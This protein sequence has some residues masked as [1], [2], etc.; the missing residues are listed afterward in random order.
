M[1]LTKMSR[2]KLLV[3]SAWASRIITSIA[4]I[5]SIRILNA[6]LQVEEY[7]IYIVIISISGWFTIIGDPGIGY[8][9]QNKISEKIAIKKNYCVDILGAYILLFSIAIFI[10][11]F[12]YILKNKI[13]FFLFGNINYNNHDELIKVFVIIA[14]IYSMSVAAS[15]SNKF[16]YAMGSG[17]FSNAMTAM[18]SLLGLAALSLGI[19]NWSQKIMYSI[20]A[21]STPI[22]M[23]SFIL[24]IFQIKKSWSSI[25]LVKLNILL[26]ILKE[27]RGFFFFS[28]IATFIIQVDYLIMTQQV[29]PVEIAQYYNIAKIFSFLAFINQ[30]ILYALW[31]NFTEKFY[32]KELDAIK[33]LIKNAILTTVAFAVISIIILI[34]LSSYLHVI[35]NSG[36]QIT[37]RDT[38]ILGFGFIALLRCVSDPCAIFLQSINNLRPL[39]I[40]ASIQAP[41]SFLFQWIFSS[42]FSIEGIILG[43]C[44]AFVITAFWVYPFLTIK[45]LKNQ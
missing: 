21:T 32:K 24:A 44:C 40:C 12:C 9:T 27:S 41:I 6:H 37:Y 25:N 16:L 45:N 18:G 33:K 4:G 28:L 23:L 17:V 7:A 22:M 35:F 30:A 29:K 15:V 3:L 26:N 42:Y 38:V 10:F 19:E 1:P 34:G 36:N 11:T 2:I 8:L 43:F 39:I 5:I 14:F 13:S 31:P 20:M